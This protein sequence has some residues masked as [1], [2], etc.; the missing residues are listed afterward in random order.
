MVGRAAAV[1]AL[2][3]VLAGCG[4]TVTI[5]ETLDSESR[6]QAEAALNPGPGRITGQVFIRKKT[7]G[8]VSNAGEWVYLVPA[9]PYA[10]AVFQALFEDKHFRHVL[11]GNRGEPDPDFMA[12]TRRTKSNRGGYFAFDKVALGRYFLTARIVWYPGDDELVPEGGW[13]YDTVEVKSPE[14]VEVILSGH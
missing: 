13:V 1:L 7:G 9:T 6:L 4:K 3:A 8:T 10:E 2:L 5:D 14:P 11:W 12:L